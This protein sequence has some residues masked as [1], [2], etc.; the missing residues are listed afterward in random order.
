MD[1]NK[2]YHEANMKIADTYG[3]T[4]VPEKGDITVIVDNK[5]YKVYFEK[6]EDGWFPG[7]IEEIKK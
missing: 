1:F 6:K 5:S 3:T 2:I 7:K 4:G